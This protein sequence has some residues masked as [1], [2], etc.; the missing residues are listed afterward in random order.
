M[1]FRRIFIIQTHFQK[2]FVRKKPETFESFWS[3]SSMSNSEV[4]IQFFEFSYIWRY[5][6]P[7]KDYK[8]FKEWVWLFFYY[9]M[10]NQK[11]IRKQI[12]APGSKNAL[13]T[14]TTSNAASC[15]FFIFWRTKRAIQKE[16]GMTALWST[17]TQWNT[18]FFNHTHVH[19]D[20]QP[21]R[22]FQFVLWRSEYYFLL[23][24]VVTFL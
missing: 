9:K 10:N 2:L 17:H 23:I 16:N 6:K 11:Y 4:R 22:Q 20:T 8:I 5:P 24:I 12:W 15:R 3:K 1:Y 14:M 19:T 21:W 18:F 13:Y 7:E